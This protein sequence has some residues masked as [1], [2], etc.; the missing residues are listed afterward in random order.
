MFGYAL[1]EPGG[2]Y[3]RM[4]NIASK[5][6]FDTAV[7]TSMMGLYDELPDADEQEPGK[8]SSSTTPVAKYTKCSSSDIRERDEEEGKGPTSTGA[9]MKPKSESAGKAAGKPAHLTMSI[10]GGYE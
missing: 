2:Y 8:S 10:A 1:P 5:H 4:L 9:G 7:L 3:E 6:N